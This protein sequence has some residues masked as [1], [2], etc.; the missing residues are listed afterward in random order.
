MFNLS[1]KLLLIIKKY[2][3]IQIKVV[4]M[5]MKKSKYFYNGIP[6]FTYCKDNN[7][8]YKSILTR[9]SKLKKDDKYINYPESEI[10]G[11]VIEAYG[12]NTKY[13]Y[14]GMSL[15]QYC[16]NNNIVFGSVEN[17]INRLRAYYP[18][19][20]DNELVVL[21]LEVYTNGHY[22]LFY[23]DEP[24]I[25][26]CQKNPHLNYDTIRLRIRRE[27]Q[28]E[29]NITSTEIDEIIEN[30]IE[31]EHKGI[32]TYYYLGIPLK[33]YCEENNMNYNSVMA[34]IYRYK[35]KYKD[36]NLSNNELVQRAMAIY[37]PYIPKYQYKGI[38]LQQ[39]CN[40]HN[41]NASSVRHKIVKE[42]LK[43]NKLLQ[44][45]VDEC[46]EHYLNSPQIIPI[47]TKYY[48]NNQTLTKFC[49]FMGYPYLAIWRRIKRLEAKAE[50]I[51]SEQIIATAIK[52]YEDKLQIDK[53]NEAFNNLRSKRVKNINEIKNICDFLK[54]NFEKVNYLVSMDFSYNQAIN[55]IWY[56][57]DELAYNDYK[58]I[59]D[60]KL[61]YLFSL[62]NKLEQANESNIVDFEL[63]DLIGIYKSELYDSRTEILLRQKKYINKTLFSLCTSYEVEI[64]KNNYEDFE[65]EIKYYLLKVIE[66]SNLNI[67]GQIVKY[68]DLTVKGY[69]RDYL[70][71][72]KKYNNN[73][74]LNDAKYVND[75]N[76]SK[77]KSRIDYIAISNNPYEKIEHTLFSSDMM[78]ALSNLSQQDLLFIV[79]K[80]QENYNDDELAEYF[81]ISI[82]ELEKKE[83]LIL[84]ILKNNDSIKAIKKLKKG[85]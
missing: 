31:E 61:E 7:I 10:V 34:F 17:R 53:I 1:L 62:V 83:N 47:E 36:S 22:K 68:M 50:L 51:N 59:T 33:Q 48:F 45:I 57:Y 43:S 39:F 26:Y 29:P 85:I 12:T 2:D 79:L 41:I 82:D 11:K 42:I 72:Y 73:L 52:K 20:T 4:M 69:F 63:Y 64:N 65:N 13:F 24:L 80:F 5:I 37:H 67:V 30:Y 81:H 15:R 35:N 70:K 55:L 6:L 75:K 78:R 38:P 18:K 25:E 14:K 60:E 58:I 74:S 27:K 21:A 71:K 76:T 66:R 54:I 49:D 16:L 44:E 19:L 46:V 3:K 77:E 9:I 23:K 8:N 40:E 32:Y 84:S 28:I 56:F